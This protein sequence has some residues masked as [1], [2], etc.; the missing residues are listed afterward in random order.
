MG[1][2]KISIKTS[3][4][5][6]YLKNTNIF[7]GKPFPGLRKQEKI[8]PIDISSETSLWK[9]LFT[10]STENIKY[11]F[12]Y[13]LNSLY[14]AESIIRTV[15]NNYLGTLK[16]V[17]QESF[18][19]ASETLQNIKNDSLEYMLDNIEVIINTKKAIPIIEKLMNLTQN[20]TK[21][22]FIITK[23]ASLGQRRSLYG[24]SLNLKDY[25]VD[26]LVSASSHG[27]GYEGGYKTKHINPYL[28]LAGVAGAT[29]LGMIA[30][31]LHECE[32]NGGMPPK[33]WKKH[34]ASENNINEI[35]S[36]VLN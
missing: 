10:K 36:K 12:L 28:L 14:E 30:K 5:F 11:A 24:H 7:K 9:A 6:G 29:L 27:N 15:A 4:I 32:V 23:P 2:S 25:Y 35:T 26:E 13:G 3:P 18:S 31:L 16:F 20:S 33:C 8:N 34:K 17:L 22:G 19:S 21:N 1:A